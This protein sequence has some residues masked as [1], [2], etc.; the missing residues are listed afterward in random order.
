MNIEHRFAQVDGSQE[1]LKLA[2][3]ADDHG[4]A[5]DVVYRD[6]MEDYEVVQEVV[7]Y[8]SNIH[9]TYENRW[10]D[11]EIAD[12]YDSIDYYEGLEGAWYE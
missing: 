8:G 12:V 5:F 1:L 6:G 2:E 11:D 7:V 9:T 3:Q 4:L 10:L